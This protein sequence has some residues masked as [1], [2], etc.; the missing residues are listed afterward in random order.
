MV[1]TR[2][3]RVGARESSGG[4]QSGEDLLNESDILDGHLGHLGP[5]GAGLPR[6]DAGTVVD[7]CE[8][9]ESASE[10]CSTDSV[11]RT[12]RHR[13][14]NSP[15]LAAVQ[16][17][18]AM[19]IENRPPGPPPPVRSND[20]PSNSHGPPSLIDPH[21]SAA[22]TPLLDATAMRLQRLESLVES[23]TLTMHAFK[24]GV[25][26]ELRDVAHDVRTIK[27]D[28]ALH[29]DVVLGL[30]GNIATG[31]A[32]ATVQDRH[33]ATSA[34][35]ARG[36][37]GVLRVVQTPP[38]VA[39]NTCMPGVVAE[40]SPAPRAHHASGIPGPAG[41]SGDM[42][43]C[44]PPS[45]S[46][47]PPPS[48]PHA[49]GPSSSS[50]SGDDVRP[51]T[52]GMWIGRDKN[53]S[54]SLKNVKL[55]KYSG[56]RNEAEGWLY[57]I[58]QRALAEGTVP[59]VDLVPF[60]V[61]HFSSKAQDWWQ[62]CVQL[63]GDRQ[64]GGFKSWDSFRAEFL[65][66]FTDHDK[67]ESVWE[68]LMQRQK[69]SLV[70]HN[71]RFLNLCS[72]LGQYDQWSVLQLY[73]QSLYPA[74][75]AQVKLHNPTTVREA[76]RYAKIADGSRNGRR[77]NSASSSRDRVNNTEVADDDSACQSGSER[78]VASGGDDDAPTEQLHFTR[79]SSDPSKRKKTDAAKGKFANA[80]ERKA[81]DSNSGNKSHAESGRH[82]RG[83]AKPTGSKN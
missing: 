78:S 42:G 36:T 10:L 77:H 63:S 47:P 23:L 25:A 43:E 2:S 8:G 68:Q 64:F 60:T 66:F 11:D 76:M 81:S 70:A 56:K 4:G 75:R 20:V 51:G 53:S 7:E 15:T 79:Q 82:S 19:A 48:H 62:A 69:G 38:P 57:L 9:F 17:A 32:P 13:G 50:P 34:P 39:A 26:A 3:G 61:S 29:S 37:P 14:L 41:V 31:G 71:E 24:A 30:C 46:P 58:E 73:L 52:S 55:E 54:L 49:S 65:D 44:S 33:E 67:R 72:R 28:A 6:L 74:C 16:P 27:S 80:S 12:L 45:P 21:T 18:P 59:A 83:K 35:G 40:H 1:G 5:T 22:Q